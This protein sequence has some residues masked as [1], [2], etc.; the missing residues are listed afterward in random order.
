MRSKQLLI[1]TLSF[2]G[3]GTGSV[4]Q[5]MQIIWTVIKNI[6]EICKNNESNR[7]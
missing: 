2:L 7:Q 4:K 5:T 6:L 3:S 1:G